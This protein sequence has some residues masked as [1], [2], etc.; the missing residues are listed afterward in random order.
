M[1]SKSDPHGID[2]RV[3]VKYEIPSG[4]VFSGEWCRPQ[5]DAPGLRS[6]TLI[7]FMDIMMN[8]KFNQQSKD[9]ENNKEELN[10]DQNDKED[11]QH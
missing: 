4:D 7:K 2:I 11:I 8:Y 10:E 1:Q 3:E 6:I 5:N 9:I